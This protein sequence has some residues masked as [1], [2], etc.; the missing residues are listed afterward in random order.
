MAESADILSRPDQAV[1]MPAVTAGCPMANMASAEAVQGALEW[2]S[3]VDP[4]WV[5]IVYVNSS[6][7][8]KACCGKWAGSTCTSSNAAAVFRWAWERNR[9]I[10][11][12][13]DEHL[14]RNTARD[15][16]VA[17]S[18][19]CLYD[20]QG[21]RGGGLTVDQVRRCRLI[22]WKGF[23]LVHTAFSVDQIRLVRAKIPDARIIVHPE[24]P[25]EVCALADAHGSTSQIIRYVEAAPRGS[26]LVIG[27]ELNLI[28]RLAEEYRDRLTIKALAPSLCANMA[29]TTEQNLLDVMESWPSSSG[30]RVPEPVAVDAR[31]PLQTMLG[32][33]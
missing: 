11:F 5:P 8:V 4:A 10:L 27:T 26:T 16:G 6:V 22:V 12:A 21:G 31:K 2:L 17:D 20:P 25:A 23:C 19:V 24:T 32:I 14:G 9:K 33:C 1:Y 7:E 29:K 30:I 28:E 13:P 18:E 3:S 15:L